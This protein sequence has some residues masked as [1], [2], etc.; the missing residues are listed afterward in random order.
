MPSRLPWLLSSACSN[1]RR[2]ALL[3]VLDRI[4]RTITGKLP[5]RSPAEVCGLI[6]LSFSQIGE[7]RACERLVRATSAPALASRTVVTVP[8]REAA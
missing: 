3:E 2:V 4:K 8:V 6:L 7:I 5:N 1:I